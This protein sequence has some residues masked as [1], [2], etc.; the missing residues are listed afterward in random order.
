PRSAMPQEKLTDLVMSLLASTV[1]LAVAVL[2][3]ARGK[4]K[5]IEPVA[6]PFALLCTNL[7]AY[8][9]MQAISDTTSAQLWR[10]L[11]AMSAALVT[12][13]FYQLVVAFV[14]RRHTFSKVVRVATVYFFAIAAACLL[15][16]F[17]E[18]NQFPN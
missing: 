15:P 2:A 11:N 4:K 9:L 18:G 17:V 16:F 14:G 5:G 12:P 3:W 1:F 13:F 6:W 10:W 7:F 8:N